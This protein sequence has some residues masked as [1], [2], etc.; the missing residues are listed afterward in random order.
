MSGAERV[1]VGILGATGA[2]GQR[3]VSL[4]GDHPWFRIAFLGASERSAGRSYG[5]AVSWIQ[6]RPLPP[7]LAETTVASCEPPSDP[8]IPLFFSALDSSV[9][10]ELETEFARAGHLVVS[11]A[12]NHRMD[13]DVPLLVPEVNP[14]HL[15]LLRRQDY[16]GGG[17]VTNPNCSTIGLVL[18]LKPLHERFG[19]ET[20]HVVTLQA[21]SGAGVPGVASLEI[22]DN[23]I[24]FIS[25]EEDKLETEPLKILGVLE[26]SGV[27]RADVRIGAHCTRVPVTDGHTESISVTLRESATAEEIREAWESWRSEPQE[28]GLPSAPEQPVRYLAGEADPQP[29]LHRNLGGGMTV[30]V[31]RLRPDPVFDWS[32]FGLSHNT[33]RGAAG[34]ALLCAELAV[35]RGMLAGARP[36]V[37]D[38]DVGVGVA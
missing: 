33:V 26:D 11:N 24:P 15:D 4:L 5:E 21:L 28:L 8:E 29:R 14:D 34:G 25:G 22:A 13:P 38:E 19:L 2:V 36:P 30:A 1:P 35:A 9:A 6:D 37:A 16:G 12:R 18:A 17:I 31:G 10:G 7:D 20:V 23:V 32:F 27:R 3:F